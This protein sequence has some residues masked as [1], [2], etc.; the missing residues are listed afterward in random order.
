MP[1]IASATIYA[2]ILTGPD[3]SRVVAPHPYFIAGT[4]SVYN[5][6]PLDLW[7]PG[8]VVVSGLTPP[9]WRA[10]TLAVAEDL[11]AIYLPSELCTDSAMYDFGHCFMGVTLS[12]VMPQTWGQVATPGS[13][14]PVRCHDASI[15]FSLQQQG[16]WVRWSAD[17]GE[18]NALGCVESVA[19][20]DINSATPD[21]SRP[22]TVVGQVVVPA[23]VGAGFT[24]SNFYVIVRIN[25][26]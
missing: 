18:Y 13:I 20:S 5:D 6:N 22:G 8:S 17:V 2:Q 19:F 23:G 9:T 7:Y 14:V 4:I 16:T 24:G 26:R 25:P 3:G 10:G 21:T 11:P 15:D 1:T 12:H